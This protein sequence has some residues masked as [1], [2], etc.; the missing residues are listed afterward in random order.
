MLAPEQQKVADHY[1]KDFHLAKEDAH[2]LAASVFLSTYFDAALKAHNNPKGL[3]NWIINELQRVIKESGKE[4]APFPPEHLAGLVR[5]IDE[6]IISTKI[7]KDVFQIMCEEGKAPDVI[8]DERGLKQVT[9]TGELA[10]IIDRIV[11]E[12]PDVVEQ[13]KA[14]RD[15]R[16]GFLVGQIMKE[17]QGKANPQLV[18]QLLKEKLSN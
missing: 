16:L 9:D 1:E 4:D 11:A 17:T 2:F 8:I 10:S 3:S 7:A 14:G 5:N 13:V 15:N 18:N 12:Y 6:E